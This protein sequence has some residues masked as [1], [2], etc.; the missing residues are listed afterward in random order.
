MLADGIFGSI[1]GFRQIYAA[2]NL[3]GGSSFNV[4]GRMD[5]TFSNNVKI[6]AVEA[7][8]TYIE[9]ISFGADYASFNISEHCEEI[10]LEDNAYLVK[11]KYTLLSGSS[12]T[13][14]TEN[15][16]LAYCNGLQLNICPN[17]S[18]ASP[19]TINVGTVELNGNIIAPGEFSCTGG[20]STDNGLPERFVNVNMANYP[21]WNLCEDI[22]TD[23]YGYYECTELRADCDYTICVTSPGDDFCGIDE[24]DQDIIRDLILGNICPFDYKWQHFAADANNDGVV[25]TADVNCLERYLHDEI[26]FNMPY[27]W[28][29]VSNTQYN[30][31]TPICDPSEDRIIVP[32]VDNCSNINMDDDPII[33]DWYGFPVGDLNHTCNSCGFRNIPP[34]LNRNIVNSINVNLVKVS[35]Q[36]ISVEFDQ[37]S[38]LNVWSLVLTPDFP[39]YN[40]EAVTLLNSKDIYWS[41]DNQKNLLK[42][43]FVEL[44]NKELIGFTLKI[45][46]NKGTFSNPTNWAISSIDTKLNNIAIA[47][48]KEIFHFNI[49]AHDNHEAYS[50]LQNPVRKILTITGNLEELID[51]SIFQ[52]DGKLLLYS[53]FTTNQISTEN[54]NPGIYILHLKSESGYKNIRFIKFD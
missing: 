31:F 46:F 34:I 12:A 37:G 4:F 1:C 14:E 11:I 19:V 24:F 5:I 18:E 15:T 2:I 54:L 43:S 41:K 17:Y 51:Y 36:I 16:R 42:L 32:A 27:K 26:P 53:K 3:N 45:K 7:Q 8:Q 30:N 23:G 9:N 33:E 52:I 47:K 13:V 21:F 6:L 48:N 20:N 38:P 10:S 50:I 25:S 49:K 39:V 29:Y 44:Q 35:D 22:E 40:I 28:K